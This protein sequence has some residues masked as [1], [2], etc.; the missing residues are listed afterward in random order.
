MFVVTVSAWWIIFRT[1]FPLNL[2]QRKVI[3]ISA[4]INNGSNIRPHIILKP[5]QHHEDENLFQGDR[6]KIR[7][8]QR[9]FVIHHM[10]QNFASKI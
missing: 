3:I 6:C 5:L 8:T 9:R 4:Y 2:K 7:A 1:L 10:L